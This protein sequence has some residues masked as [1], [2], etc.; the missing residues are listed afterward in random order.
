MRLTYG[1]RQVGY[2]GGNVVKEA[3]VQGQ[4]PEQLG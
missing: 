2:V 1:F 3:L 4:S